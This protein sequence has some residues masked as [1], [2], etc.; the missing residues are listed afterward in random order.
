MV[1]RFGLLSRLI[2]LFLGVVMCL[3]CRCI[4]CCRSDREVLWVVLLVVKWFSL[5]LM[6][7]VFLVLFMIVV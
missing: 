5:W 3:M 6:I 7:V 4:C 2:C 1:Y